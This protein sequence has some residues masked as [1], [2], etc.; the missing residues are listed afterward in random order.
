MTELEKL[1]QSLDPSLKNK[2]ENFSKSEKGDE[3]IKKLSKENK[4]DLL[5][6]VSALSDK[7]K[8]DIIAKALKNPSLLSKIKELL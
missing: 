5:K 2:I 1:M 6:K 4:N 3:L 7:E 8:N